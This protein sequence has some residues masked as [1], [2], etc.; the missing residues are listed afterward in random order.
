MKKITNKKLQTALFKGA[1]LLAGGTFTIC[2][3]VLS[4]SIY[5]FIMSLLI[6]GSYTA[7]VLDQIKSDR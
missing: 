5:G 2:A 6:G 7:V 1:V 3:M 4:E